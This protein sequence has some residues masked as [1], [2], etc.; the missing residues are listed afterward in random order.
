MVAGLGA[1]VLGGIGLSLIPTTTIFSHWSWLVLAAMLLLVGFVK[2]KAWMM[3]LVLIAGIL[4]GMFRGTIERVALYDYTEF[5]GQNVVLGGKVFEDPS[6]GFSGELKLNLVDVAIDDAKLPGQI[7]VSTSPRGKE[8]K[9]SDSVVVEGKLKPGFGTFPASMTYATLL[10]VTPGNGNDPAREVRD[11][12]GNDL[13]NAISD[14]AQ[15]LGMGILAGQKRAL[16]VDISEAFRIAGLTHIVVASGYNLTILIRFARRL[17]AKVSRLAALIGGA[18]SAFAFACVTGFSPSMTRAALVAGLSLLAWYFGRKFHPVVLLLVVAAVT[19]TI[20]PSYAWGDAG[21]YMSF[22]AFGGVIILAPLIKTYF[23]SRPVATP[24]IASLA[25]RSS[26]NTNKDSGLL[27]RFIPRKDK[28]KSFFVSIRDIFIENMSAQ[29][30]TAPIIALFMGQFAPYGLLAN[31]LVLPIVPLTMLLTFIAGIAGWLIQPIAAIVGFPAQV[32]L[33][34]IIGVARTV[35]ELPGAIHEVDFG[36]MPFLV[37]MTVLL[38][39]MIYLRWRTGYKLRD[40]N[41]VD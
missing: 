3:I 34:Y 8:I 20:N 41:P 16:P 19:A 37:A 25:T 33:D 31:L 7:W 21:W 23:W 32:M 30:I 39:V 12:F 35:S 9:R 1:G 36:I 18:A 11:A 22:M 15:S 17:F 4:I 26:N 27:R 14:P 10:T 2:H 24:V 29:I 6:V 13:E 5:I 38:G 28:V 40:S